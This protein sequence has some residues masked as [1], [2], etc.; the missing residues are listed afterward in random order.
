MEV[1]L[2]VVPDCPHEALARDLVWAAAQRAGLTD[3]RLTVTVV[4]TDEQAQRR[5][6]IGSPTFLIDGVDPF[7]VPDAPAG[8]TCRVYASS[9]GAAGVPE[10]AELGD[11]LVRACAS[12]SSATGDQ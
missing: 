7:A 6:F 8:V 4:D 9:R 2:L 11:A 1:E 3:V 12:R 10:M 5:G